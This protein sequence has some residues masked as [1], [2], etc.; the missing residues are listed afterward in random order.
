MVPRPENGTWSEAFTAEHKR[1]FSFIM[2][3]RD[4]LVENA[5]VRA[6]AQSPSVEPDFNLEKQMTA[7][8]SVAA[9]EDKISDRVKIYFEDG[10]AEAPLYLLTSLNKGEFVQGPAIILDDLQTII[11]T[12]EARATILERHVVL[13]LGSKSSTQ[14]AVEDTFSDRKVDPVQLTVMSHRFMS[15]AEQ[16]GHALQKTSV[17]VNI[18]ER[19]DFSCALFSPDGRLVANAPH[20]P[21]HLGSM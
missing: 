15:I 7:S 11:V 21:V 2:S 4:I 19:L 6:T 8:P 20:V 3:G 1:Q 13:E 12:P 16:M 17:S 10:W 9:T 18:K 14:R 5:R